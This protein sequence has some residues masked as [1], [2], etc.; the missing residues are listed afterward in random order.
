MISI[1]KLFKSNSPSTPV[2]PPKPI[3]LPKTRKDLK[4]LLKDMVVGIKT[5]KSNGWYN[6]NLLKENPETDRSLFKKVTCGF[7]L[8]R[9]YRHHH[10]AYCELRGRTRDQIEKPGKFNLPDEREIQAIKEAFGGTPL[11]HLGS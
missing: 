7:K 5:N 4:V 3:E 10:I 6:H 2:E 8:S 1:F 11:V 9:D